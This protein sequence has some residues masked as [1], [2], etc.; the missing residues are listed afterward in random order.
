LRLDR[1]ELLLAGHS[2]Y[3]HLGDVSPI[4]SKWLPKA[5]LYTNRSG[6]NMLAGTPGLRERSES[7]EGEPGWLPR[8]YEAK[9]Q[10]IRFRAIP[11][12]HAPNLE[13]LGLTVA[14]PP[15]QVEKPWTTPIDE[16]RLVELRAGTTHAFLIDFLD[17]KDAKRVAFRVHYQDAASRPQL[18]YPEQALIDERPVDLEI[19]TLPGR[20]TL[21]PNAD[22]YPVGILRRTRARHALV[23]HYE[24]FFRPIF[25]SK[26]RSNG[27]RLIPT[28]AGRPERELLRALVETIESPSP[29]PCQHPEAVEGLC[30]D[31][32]TLPLPGE[33][34]L[35]DAPTSGQE[36]AAHP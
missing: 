22:R 6:K 5:R 27:V 3:D 24:D 32:F 18:G 26:G 8:D 12:E 34:L 1:V 23:I 15:G 4:A 20:E 19:V 13:I 31:A 21:P 28:L 11:S 36:H 29:G 33:W 7:F 10:L 30:A 14:W 25:D 2:H 17:P 35:F 16:H 9:G